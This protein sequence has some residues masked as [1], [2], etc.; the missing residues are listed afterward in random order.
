MELRPHHPDAQRLAAFGTGRLPP[1]D[2][3]LVERHLHDCPACGERADDL[4]RDPFLSALRD[5]A[6]ID[7][8]KAETIPDELVAH[9]RYTL[10]GLIARGG[11][12]AVYRAEHALMERTV[13]L[14]VIAPRYLK[15]AE[16]AARF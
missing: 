10:G 12:G 13:A 5:A 2:A 4:A 7:G 6:R 9:A 8:A 1:E 3:A 15:S 11:M 16:A 14:K